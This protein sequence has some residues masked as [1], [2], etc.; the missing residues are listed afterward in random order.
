MGGLYGNV[1]ATALEDIPEEA[2]GLISGMLQQGVSGEIFLFVGIVEANYTTV[3][4]WISSVHRFCT[5]PRRYNFSRLASSL[6]VRGLPTSF[7]HRLAPHAPRD[8]GLPRAPAS[9]GRSQ[10]RRK[11]QSIYQRG[12]GC[13]QAPLA[14]P[15]LSR[16]SHGWLQLYE[17]R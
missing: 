4:L 5:R 8:T 12:K 3:C 9:E 14:T 16:P 7:V 13:P 2:R 15:Y 17:S 11:G 10:C 6:L 1:A